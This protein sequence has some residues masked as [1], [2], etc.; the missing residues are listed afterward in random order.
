MIK[1]STASATMVLAALLGA[2]ASASSASNTTVQA[3]GAQLVASL[4]IDD[5]CVSTN[6]FVTFVEGETHVAGAKPQPI[7]PTASVFVQIVTIDQCANTTIEAFGGADISP[8]D[9]DIA[10]NRRSGSAAA[11][12]PVELCTDGVCEP[13]TAIVA[14]E[15]V[16]DGAFSTSRMLERQFLSDGTVI[17]NNTSGSSADAA[18]AGSVTIVGGPALSLDEASG[19]IFTNANVGHVLLRP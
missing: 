14:L 13:T 5:P 15:L 1:A 19:T 11:T 12:F 3:R 17:F 18:V 16:A 2:P 6:V 4:F 9:I 8:D 7:P 10:G